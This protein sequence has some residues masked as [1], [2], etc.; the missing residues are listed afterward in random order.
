MIV[1]ELQESIRPAITHLI[2]LL[3]DDHWDVRRAGA[4]TLSKL[5]EQGKTSNFVKLC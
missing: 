4:D 3:G 2:T 5:S 1:A